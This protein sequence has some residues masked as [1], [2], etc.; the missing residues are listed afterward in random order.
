VRRRTRKQVVQPG[1]ELPEETLRQKGSRASASWGDLRRP[2]W[3]PAPTIRGGAGKHKCG[4]APSAALPLPRK[5]GG[6]RGTCSAWDG[7]PQDGAPARARAEDSSSISSAS[8][9]AASSAACRASAR[10]C[11]ALGSCE[12]PPPLLEAAASFPRRGA[13]PAGSSALQGA[14]VGEIGGRNHGRGG[15]R[16]RV[17]RLS[18][19]VSMLR[20]LLL[21]LSDRGLRAQQRV[22]ARAIVVQ[23]VACLCTSLARA[24]PRAQRRSAC[25]CALPACASGGRARVRTA[26]CAARFSRASGRLAA[27]AFHARRDVSLRAHAGAGCGVRILTAGCGEW[28]RAHGCGVRHAPAAGRAA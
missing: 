16:A 2:A 15:R 25:C 1:A 23:C 5:G 19:V 26:R 11:A 4:F 6:R 12:E 3:L 13:S 14:G 9:S 7:P 27:R 24:A 28:A 8:R 20:C 22:R 10:C 17:A 21:P 18:D